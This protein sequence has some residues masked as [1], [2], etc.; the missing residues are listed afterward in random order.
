ML[1]ALSSEQSGDITYFI[2]ND[3]VRITL[4]VMWVPKDDC[5]QYIVKGEFKDKVTTNYTTY[6]I[7]YFQ[8]S[9]LWDW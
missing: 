9:I 4:G 6:L 3:D 2:A 1:S 8:S 5:F 7:Y